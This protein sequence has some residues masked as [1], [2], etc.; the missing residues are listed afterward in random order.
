MA[1]KQYK[2][3]KGKADRIF[4][5]II[6]SQGKCEHCG[7]TQTL[8][9]AHI[10]SRKYNLIRCDTRNAFCL[11]AKCHFHFTANPILFAE[12]TATT[13]AQ[14]YIEAVRKKAYDRI[15]K[16]DWTERIEFLQQITENKITIQQAREQEK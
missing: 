11:C 9:T 1:I 12:W 14:Q 13:W 15:A 5:Q 7:S 8:Q 10:M 16:P 4:G 2:G 6:R 3:D